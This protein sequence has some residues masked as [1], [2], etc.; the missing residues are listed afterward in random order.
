MEIKYINN[1]TA[2]EVIRLFSVKGNKYKWDINKWQKYYQE[3]P[4]NGAASIGVFENGKIIGHYGVLP[5]KIGSYRALMGI[6]A[7]VKED[8]R[9][10]QAINLLLKEVYNYANDKKYDFICGF[11]NHN[12]S[13]VLNI[14]FKWKILGYLSFDTVS[15]IVFKK[16]K[17]YHFDYDDQWYEWKFG[18]LS[19]KYIK[20]YN[21]D[22]QWYNQLLKTRGDV[23]IIQLDNNEMINFWNPDK[24]FNREVFGWNQPFLMKAVNENLDISIYDI[25]NWYIE[26]GDSDTF[27]F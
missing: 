7:Y 23:H 9:N 10:L 20:R 19:D 6:H 26:M 27:E 13:K 11:S 17:K 12:F 22:G 3:Y 25:N 8:A 18:C 5:I 24:Y 4:Y 21:K 2:C 1:K 14:I 15:S 16:E